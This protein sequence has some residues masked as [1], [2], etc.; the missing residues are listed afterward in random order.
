MKPRLP[1]ITKVRGAAAAV[2]LVALFSLSSSNAATADKELAVVRGEVTFRLS[3]QDAPK[4]IVGS[5][6]LPD[7]AFASTA[8]KAAAEVRLPDSSI[9]QIGDN[10]NVQ[11]G[12]FQPD[13]ASGTVI[14]LKSG[15]LRFT[16]VHP[17]GKK[18]NYVFKTSTSQ[19]AVRGT[20][21]Y[22]VAGPRGTQLYCVECAPGDITMT[23]SVD[24]YSVVSGQTLNIRHVG[25]KAFDADIL[26]NVRINNPAI[27]QFLHGYS[28]FGEPM[29]KGTDFTGS[30]SG[31]SR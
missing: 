30:G 3:E 11:I 1:R 18:S 13:G 19:L 26:S 25:D 6:I 4:R 23:T 2:L 7:N 29:E 14:N 31:T 10:T 12:A 21:A 20:I 27:D 28:P 5:Q 15:A 17:A 24:T 8:F 16:I 9:I 22:L